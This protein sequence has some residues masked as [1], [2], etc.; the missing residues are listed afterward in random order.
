VYSLLPQGLGP[1]IA[2]AR[3]RFD[4]AQSCHRVRVGFEFQHL[5]NLGS[6]FIDFSFEAESAREA[7][8]VPPVPR[9]FRP[10]LSEQSHCLVHMA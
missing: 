1:R 2:A 5:R 10:G 6:G 9:H 7:A 4:C 8:V 3:R